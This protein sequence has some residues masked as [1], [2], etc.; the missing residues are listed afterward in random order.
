M[1]NDYCDKTLSEDRI[2]RLE[3]IGIQWESVIIRKWLEKYEKAKQYYKEHGNLN[4]RN[5]YVTDDEVKLGV[6]IS[7]Q[8]ENYNKGV[9]TEEQIELL[10]QIGMSWQRFS[11]K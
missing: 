6:W 9:L 4:V 3:N 8:R 1:R 10:E 7:S 5:G 11:D 2:K